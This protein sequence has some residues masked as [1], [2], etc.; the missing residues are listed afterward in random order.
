[1]VVGHRDKGVG[2]GALVLQ[3]S[4]M[5]LKVMGWR[6]EL[7]SLAAL[8][9]GQHKWLCSGAVQP[10]QPLRSLLLLLV[11]VRTG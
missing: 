7:E 3:K 8:V 11:V 2:L 1:V 4:Y 9:A 6:V 10:R 5:L